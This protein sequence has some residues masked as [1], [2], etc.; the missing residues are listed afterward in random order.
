MLLFCCTVTILGAPQGTARSSSSSLGSGH[1]TVVSELDNDDFHPR[2]HQTFPE[3]NAHGAL[4]RAWVNFGNDGKKQSDQFIHKTG[5]TLNE[6]NQRVKHF[7]MSPVSGQTSNFRESFSVVQ[8]PQHSG[9]S[10]SE[11]N[12]RIQTSQTSSPIRESFSFRHPVGNPQIST[13]NTGI[14]LNEANARIKTSQ[15]SSPVQESFS[16]RHQVGNPQISSFNT[17]VSLAEINR[18]LQSQHSSSQFTRQQGVI[19]TNDQNPISPFSLSTSGFNA[20]QA[21]EFNSRNL[22]HRSPFII[23][24]DSFEDPE[25]D[26]LNG[27]IGF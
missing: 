12:A 9:V 26:R 27:L 19:S 23:R 1:F 20:E 25:V 21:A 16:F 15:T 2:F 13:L 5:I 17:G 8:Q 18:N 4:T 6:A 10:L 22:G 14:S 3:N 11:A 24:H 7:Q